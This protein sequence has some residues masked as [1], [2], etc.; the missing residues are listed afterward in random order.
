M[1]KIPIIIALIIFNIDLIAK[2]SSIKIKVIERSQLKNFDD[3]LTED[4]INKTQ[5][6]K[7]SIPASP[8]NNVNSND[9]SNNKSGSAN[10]EVEPSIPMIECEKML[11]RF[12]ESG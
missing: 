11:L 3:L 4:S 10:P 9:M 7:E 1:Y 12:G 8:E 6:K 2:I 5:E